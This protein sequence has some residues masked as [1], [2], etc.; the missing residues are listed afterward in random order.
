ME[1]DRSRRRG[2]QRGALRARRSRIGRQFRLLSLKF[3]EDLSIEP[4][5]LCARMH[6]GAG[7]APQDAER[8][9]EQGPDVE[10]ARAEKDGDCQA[11]D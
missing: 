9:F 8:T 2:P 5:E 6:A 10:K 4:L 7:T 11:A 1:R 3:S